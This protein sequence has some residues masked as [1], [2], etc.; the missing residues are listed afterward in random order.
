MEAQ[1][2]LDFGALACFMDKK[3]MWQY[4][5]ALVEKNTPV[6]VEVIDG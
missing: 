6:L 1:T 3:L 2:L 4:K 5:L